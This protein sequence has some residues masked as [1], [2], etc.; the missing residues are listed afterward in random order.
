MTRDYHH[1]YV[2]GIVLGHAI[3]ILRKG[4][5]EQF[6][7]REAELLIFYLRELLM[8]PFPCLLTPLNRSVVLRRIDCPE[9]HGLGRCAIFHLAGI[10]MPC[11]ISLPETKICFWPRTADRQT[12]GV[13][14]ACAQKPHHT[15]LA[16]SRTQFSEKILPRRFNFSKHR[17]SRT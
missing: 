7:I 13:Q 14:F 1:R 16:A 4:D 2:S 5:L 12:R 11:S 6:N 10:E 17:V 15:I 8:K 9:F 3:K